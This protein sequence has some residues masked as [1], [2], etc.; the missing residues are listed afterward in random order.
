MSGGRAALV[1]HGP[2]SQRTGGYVY[3]ALIARELEAAATI[4]VDVV[5]IAP[6]DPPEPIA[7]RIAAT[8][9]D[10]VIADEL[11]HPELA[12]VLPTS[13][14]ARLLLVHHLGRWELEGQARASEDACLAAA[15][16]VVTT[17]V[18]SA[19]RLAAEGATRAPIVVVEP[20]ADRLPR[21]HRPP[22]TEGPVALLF[23]GA[24]GPRKR[25]LPLLDAAARARARLTIAGAPRDPAYAAEVHARAASTPGARVL[26]EVDDDALARLFAEHDALVLPSSLEGYGMVQTEALAAGTPVIASRA[27]G[28]PPSLVHGETAL[29]FDDGGL[30]G[31]IAAFASDAALRA[32]L[33]AGAARAELP[34]WREAGAAFA[35]AIAQARDARAARS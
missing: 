4:R 9:A 19:A 28:V 17:S 23:V 12:G 27:A 35:R 30:D 3:D 32:R 7:R 22:R 29:L 33:A 34:T 14:M 31:A 11:C 15:D 26:G 20:G 21:V 1:V 6:G 10:V 18:R 16:L 13:P 25:V 2:L 24:L 8:G 5:S